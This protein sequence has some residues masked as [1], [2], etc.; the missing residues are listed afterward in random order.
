MLKQQENELCFGL[1]IATREPTRSDAC[2][3]TAATNFDSW[4]L[5][6]EVV[7]SHVGDHNG[8]V[9]LTLG[10]T[11]PN[12]VD[13]LSDLNPTVTLRNWKKVLES[14][15]K[16]QLVAYF[17]NNDLF[18]DSQ[19]G[20]KAGRST[21]SA[22]LSLVK[23]ISDAFESDSVHLSLCDLSKVFDVVSHDILLS[24]L[25]KYGVTGVVRKSLV[26]YLDYRK[27]II[28]SLQGISAG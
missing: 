17:E 11:K 4:D 7:P 27:Q 9:V 24:K 25:G 5:K 21:T 2:L 15:M 22:L 6:A 14:V 18:N 20:F 12:S 3:D 28:V 10:L 26:S 19:H 16:Q 1:Y 23:N 13:Y 8:A